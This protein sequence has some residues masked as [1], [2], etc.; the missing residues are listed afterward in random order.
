VTSPPLVSVV[1]ATH[2]RA[3][4]VA[5]LLDGLRAQT[6]RDFE[7]VICDDGS[8]DDT[9]S[10]L[11]AVT[12][13]PLTVLRHPV[14]RGP[15]AARNRGWR[16]AQGRLIAFTDD[17]CVPTPAWLEAAAAVWDGEPM[18]F[19][20]GPV[21]PLAGEIDRLGAFSYT[22]VV[23]GPTANYETANMLYP[24]ALLERVGGFKEDRYALPAGEDADLGW[25]AREAGAEPVFAADALVEH[26]VIEYGPR[27]SLRRLWR[28]SDSVGPYADHPEMR[29][30]LHHGL[31]WN[32]S[33]YLLLRAL[34]GVGLLRWRW[35]WPLALWLGKWYAAYEMVEARAHAGN[36]WL[37]PWWVVRDVV[38]TAACV[39][40]SL[41]YR[42]L[43]L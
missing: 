30:T 38:E 13:L 22:I 7:V 29:Q 9:Q 14:A 16:A 20:Q 41:R 35:A 11:A 40:G 25:T 10:V 12:D 8:T 39:R 26:A 5:M 34:I 42:V 21:R 19:V 4:R 24:R 17:D 2:N 15:A 28:W 6:L 3:A 18:R 1:V 32:L 37:A 23:E 33:H 43:V 36:V 31:F 27:E